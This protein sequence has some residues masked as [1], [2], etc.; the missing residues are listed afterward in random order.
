M[1]SVCFSLSM[2]RLACQAEL[3]KR[4]RRDMLYHISV[5]FVAS[6][7]GY[8][9]KRKK[10]LGVFAAKTFILF[11]N[12]WVWSLFWELCWQCSIELIPKT[13]DCCVDIFTSALANTSK[14]M[15]LPSNK[16]SHP[17]CHHR[18]C[19][20]ERKPISFDNSNS[21]SSSGAPLPTQLIERWRDTNLRLSFLDGAT[22]QMN[23]SSLLSFTRS[24][25]YTLSHTL[26]F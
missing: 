7:F 25:L 19:H 4:L 1:I 15:M 3:P 12:S 24:H 20:R 18:Y 16:L 26:F 5:D 8:N 22:G 17:Y 14:Q 23:G 2:Y 13:Q 11:C 10:K 21:N 6:I 9:K